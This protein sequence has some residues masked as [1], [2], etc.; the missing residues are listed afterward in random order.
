ML[1]KSMKPETV[2]LYEK[3]YQEGYDLETDELYVVWSKFKV[4]VKQ[5]P[6]PP[7]ARPQYPLLH[8][9]CLFNIRVCFI[10]LVI[11]TMPKHVSDKQFILYLEN[12]KHDRNK[13][14]KNVKRE[15]ERKRKER[16]EERERKHL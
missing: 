15:H 6:A 4:L 8:P 9:S 7:P 16:E 1:E 14:R 10:Y 11:Y 5:T 3:R 2:Q 12:K 13:R